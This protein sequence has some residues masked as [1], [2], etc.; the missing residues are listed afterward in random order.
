MITLYLSSFILWG[1]SFVF[2]LHQNYLNQVLYISFRF[3]LASTTNVLTFCLP[4]N[5]CIVPICIIAAEILVSV[6]AYTLPREQ[7]LHWKIFYIY[8]ISIMFLSFDIIPVASEHQEIHSLGETNIG[9]V[10]INT[11]LILM[12]NM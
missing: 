4:V 11:S 12:R 7:G 2:F 8:S 9:Y 6:F 1:V 3:C 10:K 5:V